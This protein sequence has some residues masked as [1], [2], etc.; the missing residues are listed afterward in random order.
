MNLNDLPDFDFCEKDGAN[1]EAEIISGYEVVADVS[2]AAGDP[3]RLYLEALALVIVTQR[4]IID[5]TAKQNLLAFAKGESIDHLGALTDVSRLSACPAVAAIRFELGEVQEL[6]VTIPAGTRITPDSKLMFSTD[7]PAEIAAGNLY[8]DAAATCQT[9]GTIGNG[10]L[11]GQINRLVDPIAEGV[12]ARNTGISLGGAEVEKDD[13]FKDRVQLSPEKATTAGPAGMYEYWA[14]STHQD[15]AHVEALSPCEGCVDVIVLMNDGG[16]P[17]ADM[18]E[19]VTASLSDEKRRPLTDTVRVLAPKQAEYSIN[20]KY[21]VGSSNMVL[22]ESI[23]QRI[24]A[25]VKTFIRWQ[26]SALGRD[27]NPTK[28]GSLLE[29]AGAKR[30]EITTPV[31]QVLTEYQIAALAEDGL[32]VTY[33]GLEND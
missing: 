13:R 17:D 20:L 6:P 30:V 11:A 14:M 16:I 15:I 1:T 5:N 32:S 18:L 31:H 21:Y 28:L 29:Q 22:L 9:S 3:V 2:L 27:I 19:Q 24:D 23:Q 26:R 12:K 33:G 8:V 7:E 10:Y 25:A 4:Q